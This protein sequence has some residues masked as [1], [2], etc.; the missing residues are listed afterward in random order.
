MV[1]SESEKIY[2]EHSDMDLHAPLY[3]ALS[4]LHSSEEDVDLLE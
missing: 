4:K 2:L 1:N 3:Y